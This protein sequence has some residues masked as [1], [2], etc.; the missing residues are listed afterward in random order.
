MDAENDGENENDET[1][2]LHKRTLFSFWQC[3]LA[4]GGRQIKWIKIVACYYYYTVSQKTK[5][6]CFCQNL[7][8]FPPILLIFDR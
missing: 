1:N 6:I 3:M 5:Q 7:G 4:T 8:K 2:I